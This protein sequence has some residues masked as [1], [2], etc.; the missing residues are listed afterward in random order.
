M[1]PGPMRDLEEYLIDAFE[2]LDEPRP[3]PAAEPVD[4]SLPVP[5]AQRRRLFTHQVYPYPTRIEIKDYYTQKYTL[6]VELVKLQNW[7]KDTR[8]KLL[9]IFEGRDAAGK[10]STIKR[11]MEHMNPRGARVVALERPTEVEEGQ[12]YFQRHLRHLPGPGEIVLFDRSWYN[13]AGVERVM[14]F[15]SETQVDEFFAQV[16][17]LERM[18]VRSGVHLMKFYFSV[19]REEQ[20]RRFDQ[21]RTDPLKGWKL[22]P[23]D[24][25]SE[26]R[27]D[28]YTE[29]KEDMFRRSHTRVAPWTVVKSDDK[30][31]ARLQVMRTVLARF[32]YAAKDP[33]LEL[34]DPLLVARADEIYPEIGG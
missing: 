13:R 18:L 14:G 23:M 2:Y 1:L 34:P 21:R 24:L 12:W 25:A 7:I 15:C 8:R 30:M 33:A 3:I 10:G 27:W 32:D 20:H 17:S 4:L 16:P 31:R 6:Q 9:L 11:F 29:A 19:S 22:S 5:V 26:E 28:A